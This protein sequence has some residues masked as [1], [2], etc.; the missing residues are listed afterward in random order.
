MK[1]YFENLE[2]YLEFLEESARHGQQRA[3]EHIRQARQEM[4]P[5]IQGCFLMLAEY[6]Q[7]I[8]QPRT[9]LR[10]VLK[11]KEDPTVEPRR[12]GKY[13]YIYLA[14]FVPNAD[15]P[16]P[17]DMFNDSYFRPGEI[18]DSDWYPNVAFQ[19][20]IYVND[21][22][23]PDVKVYTGLNALINMRVWGI[24]DRDEN[25]ITSRSMSIGFDNA[26]NRPYTT[27]GI[28]GNIQNPQETSNLVQGALTMVTPNVLNHRDIIKG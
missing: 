22:Y 2:A 1:S 25:T 9:D 3:S 23:N 20:G 17:T 8:L 12:L 24:V 19:F 18:S 10:A 15:F 4:N 16:F 21:R 13:Y 27:I 14:N 28:V 6:Y 11:K 7:K 5:L 26:W